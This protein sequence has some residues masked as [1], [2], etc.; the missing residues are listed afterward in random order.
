MIAFISVAFST[1]SAF[2]LNLRFDVRDLAA[3]RR[4]IDEQAA[5]GDHLLAEP[6]ASQNLDHLA[7]CQSKLDLPKLD[8]LIVA[9]DP[10]PR[11]IAFVDYGVARNAKH[12]D[13][14]QIA[15]GI[16]RDV[17]KHLR[18]Q[19]TILVVDSRPNK[20]AARCR[21]KCRSNIVDTSMIVATRSR[22]NAKDNILTDA[23]I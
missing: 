22:Q 23:H 16:K 1:R 8:R 20:E 11:N 12:V 21:V 18:L 19:D 7:V 17:R 3:G 13:L 6:N 14:G 9:R 15:T 4:P 5:L 10:N 2:K